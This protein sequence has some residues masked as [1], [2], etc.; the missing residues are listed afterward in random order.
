MIRKF[1][2][3]D[4]YNKEIETEKAREY[5]IELQKAYDKFNSLVTEPSKFFDNNIEDSECLFEYMD[6]KDSFLSLI[7][8]LLIYNYHN[9]FDDSFYSDMLEDLHEIVQ[10]NVE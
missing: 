5:I 8:N 2:T 9:E 10:D 3:E 7:L 1:N 4:F 6:S